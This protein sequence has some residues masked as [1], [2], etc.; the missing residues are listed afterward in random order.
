MRFARHIPLF[1]TPFFQGLDSGFGVSILDKHPKSLPNW[2][3]NSQLSFTAM[4]SV[5]D[6]GGLF[7]W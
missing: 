5:G 2:V 7:T 6:S 1:A 4:T 3:R